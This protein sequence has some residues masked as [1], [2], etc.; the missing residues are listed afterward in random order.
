ML[1]LGNTLS[2]F[3]N[4]TAARAQAGV[5]DP[6]ALHST[7]ALQHRFGVK[8]P[9]ALSLKAGAKY[10]LRH[11]SKRACHFYQHCGLP[12]VS[13]GLIIAANCYRAHGTD[14]PQLQKTQRC[15]R[16]GAFPEM[17]KLFFER[18]GATDFE[19]AIE[20][21]AQ[22]SAAPAIEIFQREEKKI[23]SLQ[24]LFSTTVRPMEQ[25]R[26]A[27]ICMPSWRS[28]KRFAYQGGL[29]EAQDVLVDVDNV[30]LICPVPAPGFFVKEALLRRLL[31]RDF[32]GRLAY[33]NPGLRPLR[34]E[35][36]Y[37]LFIVVCQSWW[38]VLYLNSIKGW[39]DRCR[40][41]IVWLDELYAE[42][43]L[44]AGS[45]L[46][47]LNRFDHVVIGLG[48][49]VDALEKAL[50]RSCHWVPGA[51]D[52]LRFSPWPNPPA[53]VVDFYSMGRRLDSLHR[54]LL[55][56]SS[57]NKSFYIY[58]SFPVSMANL[59][60]HRQHRDMIANLAKRSRYFL[61]SP[62][63]AGVNSD[64]YG[65]VEIG[66]RY[67]E[68]AAAGAVMIG[69]AADCGSF[70]ELFGWSDSVIEIA[71]DGSDLYDVLQALEDQPV[72][73]Q[74]IRRRNARES[75]LRHDWVYRWK[76]IL[77]LAGFQPTRAMVA[78]EN[79]LKELAHQADND[80]NI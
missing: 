52:A 37:D 63:K 22:P 60:D 77:R 34:L 51:V 69:Q 67:F 71:E 61:V 4:P 42:A 65:Q 21:V 39:K 10:S 11:A 58:D 24:G 27:R 2:S 30:D 73:L 38:D 70:R 78:R 62:V 47:A 49:S 57:G 43:I 8:S 9:Y 13:N 14:I 26:A 54:L 15:P 79:R 23:A 40:T 18:P 41:S 25:H 66:Y 1:L 6:S 28:F 55:K 12:E 53:R 48:G 32:S 7:A 19:I 31:W 68:G 5:P 20:Q 80:Q 36:D 33:V 50:G 35:H 16:I 75:L 74:R 29:Y 59:P 3:S 76:E 46:H 44:R 64:T 17:A 45:W 72:R 56:R